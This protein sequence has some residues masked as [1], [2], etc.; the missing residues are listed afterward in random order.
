[1]N[2]DIEAFPERFFAWLLQTDLVL[3]DLDCC[4]DPS[5]GRESSNSETHN[6]DFLNSE[7]GDC[8]IEDWE[9]D[10]FDLLESEV[11]NAT[12]NRTSTS[13]VLRQTPQKPSD[14]PA[15]Q[16]RF[17]AI[18]KRRLKTEIQKN[19][20]LFPWETEISDYEPDVPTRVEPE[21]IPERH[22]WTTELQKFKLP[23]SISP[24]ISAQL[25]DRCQAV[26]QSSRTETTKLV[27]AVEPLFPGHSQMLNK[28]A[29]KVLMPTAGKSADTVD[30]FQETPKFPRSYEAATLAEQMV[31]LLLAG[32]QIIRSLTLAVSPTQLAVEREWLT[33]AGLLTLE[34]E[35]QLQ[36]PSITSVR[37]LGRFPCGGSLKFRGG[38]ALASTQRP[39]PGCLS[40]E[41]FDL[42]PDRSY[43]LEVKFQ[44]LGQKPLIF[45]VLVSG[46]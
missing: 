39:D 21:S 12:L 17:Q 24:E 35:Y 1:M 22:L 6:E 43:P 2:R 33:T 7:L 19:P 10:D 40:V 32:R 9:L 31:L 28:F 5:I 27:R 42:E 38:Q 44:Q 36:K 26:V 15:V 23:V 8:D 14:I 16:D 34:V 29:D 3:P 4:S 13:E 37:I 45:A 30:C 18:L 25:V 46:Q 20:P 11:L 41:L